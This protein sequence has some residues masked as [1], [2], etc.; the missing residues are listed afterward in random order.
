MD[1]S[2]K[3][4]FLNMMNMM[5]LN[6]G[7][8]LNADLLRLYWLSLADMELDQ[9]KLALI[10]I[11]KNNRYFPRPD[12]II[13]A[14]GIGK[15]Q[16]ELVGLS[17]AQRIVDSVRR[18]GN[19]RV[20]EFDDP[21]TAEVVRRRFGGWRQLCDSLQESKLE[22]F[23]KDFVNFYEKCCDINAVQQ[24][25]LGYGKNKVESIGEIIAGQIEEGKV[26]E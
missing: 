12:E 16:I 10:H 3:R 25:R 14:A 4:E 22:F 20:V 8:D 11:V 19:S 5:A 13:E 9:I 26:D 15:A 21:V 24:Q 6:Y 2:D 7:K 18:Y 23:K 1:D 17:E